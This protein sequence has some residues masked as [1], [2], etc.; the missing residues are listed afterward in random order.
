MMI[1][2]DSK[3]MHR[4]IK[5]MSYQIL[6]EAGDSSVC[7]VG[8]NSRGFALAGILKESLDEV[9]P[10]PADI[11]QFREKSDETILF[12]NPPSESQILVI[13]DDVIFSGETMFNC[14]QKIPELFLYQKICVTVLADR[15]HRKFPILAGIVG[16]H[17]PTKLNEH[18]EL[19]LD[20]NK[21]GQL[22]LIKR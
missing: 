17:V 10:N 6:E 9:M 13:V 20:G 18:V 19:L 16:L 11:Y 15:G 1:L 14:F 22:V 5:R 7:L 21:P 12:R 4:T 3:H 8:I 2:L